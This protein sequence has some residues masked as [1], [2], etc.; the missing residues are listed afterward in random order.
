VD[1]YYFCP[2]HPDFTG[3]CGCRK[4]EP[5][6]ILR[7]MSEWPI[8]KEQSLLIGDKIWDIQAA[9]RAGIRGFLYSGGSLRDALSVI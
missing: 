1:G 5:G 7:A 6:M 9:E 8:I 4:P 2:H 3:P